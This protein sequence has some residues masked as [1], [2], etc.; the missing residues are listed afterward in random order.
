MANNDT[1]AFFR[2]M[3]GQWEKMAGNRGGDAGPGE[4]G[5]RTGAGTAGIAA[6]ALFRD[7]TE[8]ALAAANLPVRGDLEAI[9]ARLAN[10]ESAL[11][12]IETTLDALVAKKGKKRREARD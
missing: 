6:Q 7:M 1:G 11:F 12:R 3:L 8:K 5:V 10:I 9:E 2:E 4:E